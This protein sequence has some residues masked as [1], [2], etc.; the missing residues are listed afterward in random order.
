[1][2]AVGL[3]FVILSDAEPSASEAR[4]VKDLE[5]ACAPMRVGFCRL[6]SARFAVSRSL[7]ALGRRGLLRASSGWQL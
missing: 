6:S 5:I 4:R 7:V 2:T 3:L 1:V